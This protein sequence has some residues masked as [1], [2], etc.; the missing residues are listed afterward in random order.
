MSF[1]E[2]DLIYRLDFPLPMR[3]PI[4]SKKD[5]ILN[6]NQYRNTHWASLNKAK[7]SYKEFV[8]NR[9]DESVS[10]PEI[11]L[12]FRYIIHKGD[13]RSYDVANIAAIISKFVNDALVESGIIKDDNHKII[14]SEH[15]EVG[16]EVKGNGCAKL[17]VWGYK[18]LYPDNFY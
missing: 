18:K 1:S 15:Y 6:L 12:H 10:M 2:D 7:Q 4:S 16:E 13:G 14:V 5:F 17:T 8:Q 3:V 11:P 9:L